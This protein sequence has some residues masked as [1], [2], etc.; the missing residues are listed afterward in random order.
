[1]VFKLT[2][3]SGAKTV[4]TETVLHSFKGG[5]DGASLQASLI[6][7]ANGALCGTT[8]NNHCLDASRARI[9]GQQDC[10][11]VFRLT[12]PAARKPA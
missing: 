9:P 12:P 3:P 6:R 10:G 1:M 11:T 7:D 4:W 8:E 2:P 5:N